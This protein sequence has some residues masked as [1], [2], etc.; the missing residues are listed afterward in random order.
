MN[1]SARGLTIRNPWASLVL[2][3]EKTWELRANR[4]AKRGTIYVIQSGTGIVFG[5]VQM[6]EVIGP[7]SLNELRAAEAL[8]GVRDLVAPPYTNT[9]AW[10]FAYPVLFA[11]P[12]AYKHPNG[13]RT[14]VK[15]DSI[16]KSLVKAE[17]QALRK[18]VDDLVDEA[19]PQYASGA[20][21]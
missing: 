10:V 14:W 4:T 20:W 13:A 5:S 12:V 3:G 7:L 8:H 18:R 16:A 11:D 17:E 6:I 19:Y 9:Y 1:E 2:S 15:L 21:E